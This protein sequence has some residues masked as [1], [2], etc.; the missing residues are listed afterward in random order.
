[1]GL[2][3]EQVLIEVKIGEPKEGRMAIEVWRTV[4]R[5]AD[6]KSSTHQMITSLDIPIEVPVR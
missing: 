5:D 6:G 4:R 3:S 1:M 2:K